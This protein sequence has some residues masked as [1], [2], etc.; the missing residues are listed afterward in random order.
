MMWRPPEPGSAAGESPEVGYAAPVKLGILRPFWNIAG[1]SCRVV[2]LGPG[3]SAL[4]VSRR[5]H[6]RFNSLFLICLT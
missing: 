3:F 1:F 4:L 5:S 6:R 2:V